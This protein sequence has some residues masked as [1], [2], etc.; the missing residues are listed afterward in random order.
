MMRDDDNVIFVEKVLRQVD[1]LSELITNLLNVSKIE[2]GKLEL[3]P[4]HFDVNELLAEQ[5]ANLQQTTNIHKIIFNKNKKKLII[6][7]DR[8]KIE[9]VVINIL[10]NAI[11]YSRNQG[12]IIVD[13]AKIRGYIKVDIKDEGIGIPQKDIKNIFLRFFRVSGSASSF[14]GSGVGLYISSEIIKSHKGNIWVD[15]KLGEGSVF[16]FSLPAL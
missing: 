6:N 10:N 5:V 3:N 1:K 7:A 12:D 4:T 16:H 2:A 13:A 14:S 9:Q 15:S 8:E 11:K